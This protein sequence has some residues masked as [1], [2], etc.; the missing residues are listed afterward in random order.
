ML[1]GGGHVNGVQYFGVVFVLLHDNLHLCLG[2][3]LK[4]IH[5]GPMVTLGNGFRWITVERFRSGI[6]GGNCERD[7]DLH[8]GHWKI[9]S[10]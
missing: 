7:H 1:K 5:S 4:S 10:I 2:F 6:I 3:V 9:R 8:H